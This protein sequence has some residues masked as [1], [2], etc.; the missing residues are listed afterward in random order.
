[1]NTDD[2]YRQY[3]SDGTF[4]KLAPLSIVDFIQARLEDVVRDQWRVH[5]QECEFGSHVTDPTELAMPQIVC[6]C[7]IPARALRAVEA[8]RQLLKVH[9]GH[10]ECNIT[11]Q[12]KA[13]LTIYDGSADPCGCRSLRALVSEWSDHSDYQEEWAL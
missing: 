6:D 1:M 3:N 12:R 11:Y 10:H 5:D 7:G 8:K 13:I 4:A 2:G 9:E